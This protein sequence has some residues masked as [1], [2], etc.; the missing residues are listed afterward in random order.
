MAGTGGM[1]GS[2]GTA[3]AGGTGPT[4]DPPWW[5]AQWRERWPILIQNPCDKELAVGYQIGLRADGYAISPTLSWRILRWNGSSWSDVP[6][7]VEQVGAATWVWFGVA[8]PIPMHAHDDSY[9]LYADNSTAVEPPAPTGLFDFLEDFGATEPGS[10]TTTGNV[11]FHAGYVRLDGAGGNGGSI[12]SD[13]KFGPGH[14]IDFAMTV[15]KP[16]TSAT[17]W[18]CGGFQREQDF[19]DTV[20]WILWISRSSTSVRSEFWN[21]A[22]IQYNG[23]ETGVD[24]GVEHVYGIERFPRRN[25]FLRDHQEFDVYSFST[26]FSTPLQIR[27]TAYTDSVLLVRYARIRKAC[28]PRPEGTI[29]SAE[30]WPL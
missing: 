20:P 6:R 14:A 16:K 22:G 7:L 3:G 1:A 5:N 18:F 11:S 29:G 28:D 8:S 15:D 2:A 26:D 23:K 17:R 30:V 24:T 10:W 12:R 25:V 19:T 4:F 21:G 13:V 9:W 27:F